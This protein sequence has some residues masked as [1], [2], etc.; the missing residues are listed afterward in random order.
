MSRRYIDY[1]PNLEEYIKALAPDRTAEDL[2]PEPIDLTQPI[3]TEDLTALKEILG[4]GSNVTP[5]E[6]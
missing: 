3:V 4:R 1:Y 6:D 5:I 2:S